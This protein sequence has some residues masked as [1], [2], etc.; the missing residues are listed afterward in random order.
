MKATIHII[1]IIGI[2]SVWKVF[3]DDTNTNNLGITNCGAQMSI[4][5]DKPNEN[6]KTNQP[7]NL[8][9]CIT[10]VSDGILYIVDRNEA[11]DFSFI[12]ISP[13]SKDISPI[14]PPDNGLN[15][16]NILRSIE[17]HGNMNYT[18]NL[19]SL[20]NLNEIGTYKVIARRRTLG[21]CE[22]VSN[23][24]FVSVVQGEWKSEATNTP[25]FRF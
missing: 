8:V 13:S 11:I 16:R 10:N 18:F 23:T 1:L 24:L 22:I 2:M 20:C 9:I 3:A 25:A 7:V 6:I 5:L 15:L 21:N 12:V 17:P 19:R 4:T 14:A